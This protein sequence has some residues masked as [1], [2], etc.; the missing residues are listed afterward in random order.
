MT[1]S[2][3]AVGI[4][5]FER[6]REQCLSRGLAVLEGLGTCSSSSSLGKYSGAM[7]K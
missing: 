6:S 1:E 7:V 2:D 4:A 3:I 5:V